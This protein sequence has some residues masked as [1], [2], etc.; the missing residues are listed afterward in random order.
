M[1]HSELKGTL[2]SARHWFKSA[3]HLF[4]RVHKMSHPELKGTL[5]NVR[6]WFKSDR[7]LSDRDHRNVT[8]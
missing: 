3:R 8:P 2:N 6:H 7:H 1:S 4:N 5:N